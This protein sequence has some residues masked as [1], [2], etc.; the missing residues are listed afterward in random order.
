MESEHI[1]PNTTQ[2]SDDEAYNNECVTY[3]E[4]TTV[5]DADRQPPRPGMVRDLSATLE[6]SIGPLSQEL[7]DCGT[8]KVITALRD[9]QEQGKRCTSEEIAATPVTAIS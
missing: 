5:T 2:A 7:M 3:Y 9:S 8:S 1:I 6:T 4:G